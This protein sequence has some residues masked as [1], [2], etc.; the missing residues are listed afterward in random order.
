MPCMLCGVN[1]A[2]G[3]HMV[4]PSLATGCPISLTQ[5]SN[6]TVKKP[7]HQ[8]KIVGAPTYNLKSAEDSSRPGNQPTTEEWDVT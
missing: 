1:P 4:D 8:C 5:G 6:K 2:V 3:E 7:V